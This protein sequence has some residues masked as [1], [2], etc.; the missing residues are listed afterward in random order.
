[1][2]SI[3]DKGLALPRPEVVPFRLTP[4]MV[5][6]FGPTGTEGT[7]T[8]GLIT[9]M[10]ILRDNRDVLLSVLEP[11]LKDPVIEWKRQRSGQQK[12]SKAST[13]NNE[14]AD[15]KRSIKIIDGR[16][17]GI[18]NL[19]NPNYRKIRRVD[20]HSVDEDDL[21]HI[22]PMSVEGQVHK[23]ISEASSPEN[24]VQLYVGWMPWL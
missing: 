7:Y 20:S 3:F 13:P 10:K 18:Y 24:L 12:Q 16:L 15:A 17:R 11:F 5:D 14:P 9:A 8:G 19:K 21:S 6:V 22:L 2:N 1:M 4:N 23:M